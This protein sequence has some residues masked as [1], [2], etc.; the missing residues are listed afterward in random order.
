ME[1]L[2]L[3]IFTLRIP[4]PQKKPH[5]DIFYILAGKTWGMSVFTL[6]ILLYEKVVL[7]K[8]SWMERVS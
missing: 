8:Q 1:F 2:D 5:G 7:A 3:D 6:L 4:T